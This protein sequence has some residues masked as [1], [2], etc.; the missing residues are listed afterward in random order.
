MNWDFGE[1]MVGEWKGFD[2]AEL[3]F[4]TFCKAKVFLEVFDFW[5]ARFCTFC[6]PSNFTNLYLEQ[7]FAPGIF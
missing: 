3:D 6:G 5:V 1:A 4:A 7:L 2:E